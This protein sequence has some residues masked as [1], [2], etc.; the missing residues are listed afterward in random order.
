MTENTITPA[1]PSTP[2]VLTSSNMQAT[3]GSRESSEFE[4]V[5]NTCR[6]GKLKRCSMIL[7]SCE[8]QARPCIYFTHALLDQKIGN[9]AFFRVYD[10][11]NVFF[12][13]NSEL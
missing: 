8:M 12:C 7:R 13:P 9:F 3:A 4:F 1:V 10:I 2:A 6:T 11:F 5:G